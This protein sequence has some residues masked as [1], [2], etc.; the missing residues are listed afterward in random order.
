MINNPIDS[1]YN[2]PIYPINPREKEIA[3]LRAYPSVLKVPGDIDLAVIVLSTPTVP[4][5][6]RSALRRKSTH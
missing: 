3:G 6:W 5:S 1:G 4:Q 2:G